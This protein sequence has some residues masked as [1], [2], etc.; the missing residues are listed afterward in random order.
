MILGIILIVVGL[1]RYDYYMYSDP[2][3]GPEYANAAAMSWVYISGFVLVSLDILGAIVVLI[4]SRRK[5]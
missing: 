2:Y 3:M 4:R 1:V 5:K